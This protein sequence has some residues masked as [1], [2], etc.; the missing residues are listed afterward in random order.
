MSRSQFTS[1]RLSAV[2]LGPFVS[3]AQTQA[4]TEL[5]VLILC[6]HEFTASFEVPKFELRFQFQFLT[7][8]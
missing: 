1:L 2:R 4:Q 5:R 3:V 7:D 6:G 8:F